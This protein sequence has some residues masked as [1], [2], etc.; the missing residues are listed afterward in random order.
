[1]TTRIRPP[2]DSV[3][4]TLAR[5]P[6]AVLAGGGG[7]VGGTGKT[8]TIG[9]GTTP[10]GY[11]GGG[12]GNRGGQVA[13]RDPQFGGGTPATNRCF[14]TAS[15]AISQGTIAGTANRGGGGS[16]NSAGGKGVVIV[17]Y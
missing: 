4:L 6:V 11:A 5:T 7:G 17:R 14:G 13:G 10:V 15:Q 16:F 12:S 8:Y 2:I 1:M 3:P 9:D